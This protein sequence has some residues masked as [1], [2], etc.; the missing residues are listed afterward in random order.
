MLSTIL[1]RDPLAHDIYTHTNT[2]TH[3]HTHTHTHT[4]TNKNLTEIVRSRKREEVTENLED[5]G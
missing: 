4:H 1:H 2:H 3:R 5:R